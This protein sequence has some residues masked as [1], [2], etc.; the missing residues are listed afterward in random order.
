MKSAPRQI[1]GVACSVLRRELD[2][3]R[4]EGE[5]D[6]P[7]RYLDSGL[8]MRPGR[9]RRE[10][11]A[12]L[13]AVSGP[14]V[15]VVLIYGECHSYM[16]EHERRPGVWRIRGRNC[17]EILLGA[18]RYRALLHSGAFFLLPE[19]A[20]KWRRVFGEELHLSKEVAREMMREQHTRL[21]YLDTG[22]VP[23][24]TL[25]L[26]RAGEALGLPHEVLAVS[27]RHLLEGVREVLDRM[28]QS[29]A[30]LRT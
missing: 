13:D 9:L 17:A 20:R 5:I 10:L 11:E 23:V 15:A 25:E 2:S 28:K 24:P 16:D 7:I 27:T 30:P 26:E 6:F 18:D 21:V 19:W 8:H 1:V 22:Q 12:V 3:L 29:W 14:G 4:R